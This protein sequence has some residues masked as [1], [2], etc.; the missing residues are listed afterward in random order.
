M[1]RAQLT[2]VTKRYDDRYVHHRTVLD[3]VSLTVRPGERLGVVGDNGSG[4]STL[5]RLLAGLES[6]DN[7]TVAV[8]APGGLG[9]LA[10][11]LDLPA[12]A[13][14]GDA[15]D[16]ALAEIREL[17]REIREAEAV[18][19]PAGLDRYAALLAAYEAR[20]GAGAERRVATVLRRPSTPSA[21]RT[22]S[23]TRHTTRTVTS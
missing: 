21:A 9:H 12:T 10:Q 18:L 3:R 17:E 5:L 2:E 4:K 8:D 13:T 7:G 19:T 23:R 1:F 6:A 15:V 11:T 16:H 14:V 20:G 22:V